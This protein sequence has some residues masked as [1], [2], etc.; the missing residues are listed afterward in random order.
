MPGG[1]FYGAPAKHVLDSARVTKA[2][3]RIRPLL[4]SH[5]RGGSRMR[6]SPK[7]RDPALPL[8]RGEIKNPASPAMLRVVE[9]GI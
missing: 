6:E 7:R 9:D 8:R 5:T 1:W 3:A 2:L 4:P